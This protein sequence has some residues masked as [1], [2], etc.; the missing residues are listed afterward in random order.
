VVAVL[1]RGLHQPLNLAR[2]EVLAGADIGIFRP[3]RGNCSYFACWRDQFEMQIR[4]ENL[5]FG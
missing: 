1:A 2:R 5:T 3:P 4:H